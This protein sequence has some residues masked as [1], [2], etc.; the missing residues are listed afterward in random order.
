MVIRKLFPPL[1]SGKFHEAMAST[2]RKGQK[3]EG[4]LTDVELFLVVASFVGCTSSTDT[5]GAQSRYK[6][7]S[8]QPVVCKYATESPMER[9]AFRDFDR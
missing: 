4:T 9:P 3:G 6:H 7:V 2:G 8:V 5:A 1:L